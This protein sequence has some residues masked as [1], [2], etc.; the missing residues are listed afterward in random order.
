MEMSLEGR[1]PDEFYCHD[2]SHG[3]SAISDLPK[4]VVPIIAGCI[5]AIVSVLGAAF[6]LFMYCTA[7]KKDFRKG[8]AQK[9]ITLL[10][11]ADIGTV[12]SLMLGILN[13]FMYK[14]SYFV[15]L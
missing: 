4:I 2:G 5:S 12:A 1:C 11:L 15:V 14:H 10:A 9:I 3:Y 8:M 7:L 6:I 13:L